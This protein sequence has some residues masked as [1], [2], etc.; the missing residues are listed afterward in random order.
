MRRRLQLCLILF[1]WFIAT[2]SQWDLV[3]TFAWGRMIAG[4]SRTMPLAQAVRKTFQ[5]DNLCPIC[6]LV[7]TAK[8][9]ESKAVAVPG[10]SA[11]G[12]APLVF[13]AAAAVVIA[14]PAMAAL[15]MADPK[16]SGT[17]RAAPLLPPPR[18]AAA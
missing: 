9:Q 3:Q 8:Q 12:R 14:P 17:E 13:Q 6:E 18:I 5:P 11:V 4:Y 1:A 2:G 16:A 10:S 7:K 15:R